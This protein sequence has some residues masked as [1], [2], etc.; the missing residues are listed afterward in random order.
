M[1]DTSRTEVTRTVRPANEVPLRRPR[2]GA[3]TKVEYAGVR[4]QVPVTD[5]E[6][7][8]VD[9]EAEELPIGNVDE[10]L[11]RLA[12]TVPRFGIWHRAQLVET[13]EI[14]SWQPMRFALV[15]I[16]PQ[17]NMAIREREQRLG[18]SERIQV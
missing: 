18:L 13:I 5:I 17:S 10:R 8:V 7:L 16:S 2:Q 9:Q 4:T 12:E 3:C 6:W 11:G 1:S 15:Q 14:G